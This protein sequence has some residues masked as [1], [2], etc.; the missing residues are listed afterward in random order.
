MRRFEFTDPSHHSLVAVEIE[1]QQEFHVF[2]DGSRTLAFDF[3]DE[4]HTV[5]TLLADR[6]WKEV[7]TNTTSVLEEVRAERHRQ[8]TKW[9]QQNPPDLDPVL[10]E[11]RVPPA[12]H[13]EKYG[14]PTA[15]VAR[16]HTETAMKDGRLT[17]GHI[18]TEEHAEVIEAAAENELSAMRMELIQVA[19]VAVAWVE[20]I[21][22]RPMDYEDGQPEV[23]KMLREDAL[24]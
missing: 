23:E 7:P 9:G 4:E 13:A 19:A 10:V 1:G 14:I 2:D 12:R 5:K 11:R 3:I 21:D 6:R 8:D 24:R 16:L 15:A 22:R 17:W 20:A 18:L